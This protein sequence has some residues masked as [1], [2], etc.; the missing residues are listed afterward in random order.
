VKSTRIILTVL[1]CLTLI[2]GCQSSAKKK[3][4]K[5]EQQRKVEESYRLQTA[6]LA[7]TASGWTEEGEEISTAT[8][9][10]LEMR[11]TR[12]SSRTS[13]PSNES[14]ERWARAS[15]TPTRRSSRT[16]RTTPTVVKRAEDAESDR[17]KSL[18]W[19]LT[20]FVIGG[21]LI[22][23]GGVFASMLAARLPNLPLLAAGGD[24]AVCGALLAGISLSL[25]LGIRAIGPFMWIPGLIAALTISG[26]IVW[27]AWKGLRRARIKK[28]V[29]QLRTGIEARTGP[30]PN[31]RQRQRPRQRKARP[32]N[33]GNDG[34]DNPVARGDVTK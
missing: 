4:A 15:R 9:M 12:S 13:T 28:A 7:V 23:V 16:S 10:W 8:K 14:T 20:A 27:F 19:W 21:I 25:R 31:K 6:N 24:L 18:F 11:P 2:G 22:I 33:T 29:K 30:H 1:L 34:A 5:L 32:A 3:A 26:A 17:D